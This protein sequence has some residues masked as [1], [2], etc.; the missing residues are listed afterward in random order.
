M[1]WHGI[2]VGIV[3]NPHHLQE[4]HDPGLLNKT[5]KSNYIIVFAQTPTFCSKI[6]FT[7]Y[8]YFKQAAINVN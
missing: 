3:L 8:A 5:T 7:F 4:T 2:M 1:G 6:F